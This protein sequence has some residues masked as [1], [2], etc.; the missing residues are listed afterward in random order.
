MKTQENERSCPFCKEQIKSDAIKCKYCSSMLK[1]EQPPHE[2]ICPYCKEEINKDAVK[3]KHCKSILTKQ[4]SG[5]CGCHDGITPQSSILDYSNSSTVNPMIF[6]NKVGL[7]N[8]LKE[9][10]H[11][12]D[13][14]PKLKRI[15]RNNLQRPSNSNSIIVVFPPSKPCVGRFKCVNVCLP[16]IGC[17]VICYWEC[18]TF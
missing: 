2:G 1:L 4:S 16:F 9:R 14:L 3:C 6:Y 15:H 17:H 10:S 5:D 7:E 11:S 12:K 13:V 18:E 8:L